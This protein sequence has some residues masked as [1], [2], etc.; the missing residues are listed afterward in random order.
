ML[1]PGQAN[2]RAPVGHRVGS[3]KHISSFRLQTVTDRQYETKD[4]CSEMFMATSLRFSQL[5]FAG[6]ELRRLFPRPQLGCNLTETL[7][8]LHSSSNPMNL[9]IL[10]QSFAIL[11][12]EAES[13]NFIGRNVHTSQQA[14]QKLPASFHF[15]RVQ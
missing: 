11:V 7:R 1:M 9:T 6:N 4:N 15:T 10:H 2:A 8:L 14:R 3:L 5:Y 12:P 13:L